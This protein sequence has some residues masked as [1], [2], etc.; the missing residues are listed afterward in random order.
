MLRTIL[1]GLF[2]FFGMLAVVILFS[3]LPS[4]EPPVWVISIAAVGSFFI[5]IVVAFALF[6]STGSPKRLFH[7]GNFIKEL[8]EQEQLSQQSF[9]AK[10]VFQIEEF[11]DEGSHYM[12]ELL[13]GSVL[14][15]NGQ[16]LYD[17]EQIDD[18]PE[19]NQLRTFPCTDFTI[20]RHKSEGYVVD[21]L[22]RGAVLEPECIAPPFEKKAFKQGLIPEDGHIFFDQSYDDLIIE[23]MQGHFKNKS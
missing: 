6:N 2:V 5:L 13:S 22:C 14:Y 15:L 3:E 4:E 1:A 18:D 23:R 20:Q 11:E 12:I 21:I 19:L 10:R 8:E 7:P 16:Y 17:Y 9:Q